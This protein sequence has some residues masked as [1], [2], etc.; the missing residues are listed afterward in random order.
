MM[1]GISVSGLKATRLHEL[2][3]RFVLGGAITAMTGLTAMRWGPVIGGLFLAFPA[4]FPASVT[5]VEAHAVRQKKELGLHGEQR[6]RDESG[7][8]AAGA[9][10]GSLGLMIFG[11]IMYEYVDTVNYWIVLSLATVGWLTVSIVVWWIWKRM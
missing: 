5:L 9:A 10:I 4:I 8:D 2:V 11:L 3:V 7:A 1:V 6:G